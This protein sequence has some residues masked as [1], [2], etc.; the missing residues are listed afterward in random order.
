[1]TNAVLDLIQS[2][3]TVIV[4]GGLVH[5]AA[6]LGLLAQ[7]REGQALLGNAAAEGSAEGAAVIAYEAL[8]HRPT[9]EPCVAVV[10]W[11]VPG[12]AD[13]ARRWRVL[14]AAIA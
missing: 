13:Y 1:M 12:L 14:A 2:T 8:G 5:N 10:P 3:N 9:L 6:Y 7:L 4:D 11:Q